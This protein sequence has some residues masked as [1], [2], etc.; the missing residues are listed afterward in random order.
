[1]LTKLKGG[2]KT[3]LASGNLESEKT[4]ITKEVFKPLSEPMGAKK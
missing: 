4:Q 1:M 2:K 3:L